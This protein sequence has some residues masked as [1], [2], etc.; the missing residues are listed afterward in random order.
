MDREAS[1]IYCVCDWLRPGI[2]CAYCD[3]TDA[4]TSTEAASSA[5]VTEAELA[6]VVMLD[7]CQTLG[8]H[9]VTVDDVCSYHQIELV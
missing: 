5:G 9:S 4:R 2:D 8:P 7:N 3:C 6:Y 1:T